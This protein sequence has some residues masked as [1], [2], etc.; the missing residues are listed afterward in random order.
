MSLDVF[1]QLG[2]GAARL[3]SV[4]IVYR[5]L[6][7]TSTHFHLRYWAVV[8]LYMGEVLARSILPTIVLGATLNYNLFV[9]K[10]Y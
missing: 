3:Y 1:E 8:R 4:N 9:K 2:G 10:L 7:Q 6:Y 5:L